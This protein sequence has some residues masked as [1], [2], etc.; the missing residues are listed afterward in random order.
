LVEEKQELKDKI[1]ALE[2]SQGD[3]FE[4]AIRFVK[5]AKQAVFVAENGT[6]EEKRD[7]LKKSVRT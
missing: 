1:T 6:E 7:F 2:A 3:W 5:D 4:P